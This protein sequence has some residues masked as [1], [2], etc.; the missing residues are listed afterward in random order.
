[1]SDTGK[2]SFPGDGDHPAGAMNPT[3]GDPSLRDPMLGRVLDGRYRLL[4]PLATG[5][6]GLVYEAVHEVLGNRLAIKLL[7]PDIAGDEES[8]ARLE[9]EAQAATSIGNDHIV[10][11]RDFGRLS[12]GSS[13]VVMELIEGID[14]LTELRAA[15][16][17]WP[18]ACRIALQICE[19]LGAAHERGIV[20]RDLKAENVL[21]TVR[22]GQADFVKIVDFGIAKVTSGAKPLTLAGRVMGT[23]EYMAPEQCAGRPVDARADIY[24]SG[25][26]LYE[27]TTGTLPFYDPDIV[28]LV[29]KQMYEAPVPPSQVRPSAEL[30]PAFEAVV[31]R[32]LAKE[33]EER[34]ASMAELAD[35]LARVLESER[36]TSH[37]AWADT[38]PAGAVSEAVPVVDAAATGDTTSAGAGPP[39]GHPAASS[40]RV[41]ASDASIPSVDGA[42][43]RDRD[44]TWT[45]EHGAL[46][47]TLPSIELGSA[48]VASPR[49]TGPWARWL[50]GVALVPIAVGGGAWA[51]LAFSGPSTELEP[52]RVALEHPG[53]TP[54]PSPVDERAV[55]NLGEEE[56]RSDV[57]R[58][59]A[60]DS[61]P[62]D[63]SLE[64]LIETEPPGA[65]VHRDGVILGV[66]P[67]RVERTA[68]G[69]RTRLLLRR[70][71]YRTHSLTLSR[72]TSDTLRIVL[73]RAPRRGPAAR[74]QGG[75]PE[76]PVPAPSPVEPESGSIHR[77]EFMNPWSDER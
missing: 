43:A 19:A 41:G 4:R 62:Q 26:L 59:T 17:R 10:D 39:S 36:V 27:M 6:M 66:T 64:T 60:L 45:V 14:L 40:S 29:R 38:V 33:P 42:P 52:A 53:N 20:H 57:D 71:G 37:A 73:E 61:A 48:P 13:Y 68:A 76:E 49:S 72:L 77:P 63:A 23:P 18:R 25:V 74:S 54:V 75:A 21:L 15:P 55:P 30:P 24:A 7:R 3:L 12:D 67:L 8:L 65:E 69:E 31:L 46:A 70:A 51:W 1:M 47:E 11:V 58:G 32:C 34:F 16:L 35:A 28:K 44:A 22:R 50:V 56:R 2:P 9:R 5:G